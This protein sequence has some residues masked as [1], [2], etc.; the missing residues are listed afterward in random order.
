MKALLLALG[1]CLLLAGPWVAQAQALSGPVVPLAA[2]KPWSS[3]SPQ[4]QQ[5]LAPLASRWT[6]LNAAERDHWLALAAQLP[7]MSSADQARLQDR[8]QAW[9]RM[10]PDERRT[11][12]Q[13]FAGAQRMSESERQARW[14][15]YQQLPEDRRQALQAR[16]AQRAA[17]A[18]VAAPA[19]PGATSL[20]PGQR[21]V[22]TA[23]WAPP[24]RSVAEPATPA[25]APL[26]AP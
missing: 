14:E 21:S 22:A 5:A 20:Q 9:A 11:A 23:P 4:Q 10:S 18:P 19:R 15:A 8:M 1:V 26:P 12:R 3:L 25:S 6:D 17:S 13:G 16:A 24:R 7:T 2:A